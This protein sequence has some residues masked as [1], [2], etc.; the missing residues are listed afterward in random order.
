MYNWQNDVASKTFVVNLPRRV[1]RLANLVPELT[2]RGIDFTLIAA[3]EA[4]DGRVGISMTLAKLLKEAVEKNI[5]R[6]VVF[7]DDMYFVDDIKHIYEAVKELPQDF[8]MCFFGINL[9]NGEAFS[10]KLVKVRQG[11]SLHAVMYSH[12]GAEKALHAIENDTRHPSRFPVDLLLNE[13][14]ISDG[15]CY[16]VT[17]VVCSQRPSYS[18]IEKRFVD[19]SH[20]LEKR[21]N[22]IVQKIKKA[23]P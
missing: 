20:I 18:D 22:Q 4:A 6:F 23:I 7:E 21:F 17:P 10:D 8:D 2:Q 3:I 13:K 9:L 1:D 12:Q 16:A 19:Y 5:D 14:V 11:V 15:N